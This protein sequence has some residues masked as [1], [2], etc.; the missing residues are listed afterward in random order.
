MA[1]K[2]K[3]IEEPEE[4]VRLSSAELTAAIGPLAS[5]L[6]PTTPAPPLPALSP[7]PAPVSVPAKQAAEPVLMMSFKAS[8]PFAK[9]LAEAAEPEGGLRKLIARVFSEAG[10]NVPETDLKG[11]RRRR[12]YD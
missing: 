10:Y 7:A 5:N 6:I 1:F 9:M 3:R 11:T 4:P 12:T 8:K 2:P